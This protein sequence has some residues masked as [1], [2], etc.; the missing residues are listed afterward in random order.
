MLLKQTLESKTLALIV[1]D[2]FRS[3]QVFEEYGLDFCCKGKRQ[4]NIACLEK[5]IPISDV[6]KKLESLDNE[7][8]NTQRYSD[9]NTD[10]LIDYIIQQHHSYVKTM[11]PLIQAHLQKVVNAHSAKHPEVSLIQELFVDMS[12]ELLSHL[13]Q[14]ET[15]VFPNLKKIV[16]QLVLAKSKLTNEHEFV[17]LIENLEKEHLDVGKILG[18]IQLLTNG[19]TP[20][21]GAC[22]TF[23]VLYQEL[24]AFQADMFRH[25][26]LENNILFP[27]IME[28]VTI[29]K[30]NSISNN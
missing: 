28:M 17:K 19:F 9:W 12:T 20:P 8:N 23:R 29:S 10:F 4:L 2:D 25:I 15:V 7:P 24:Q 3:V 21:P 30:S 6:L 5:G 14:E 13:T 16:S 11:I 26:H 27:K 18:E 22:T 1:A